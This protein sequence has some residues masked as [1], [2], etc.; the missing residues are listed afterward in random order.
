M[1]VFLCKKSK[2]HEIHKNFNKR[3]NNGTFN[4]ISTQATNNRTLMI[5][6][7]S[8]GFGRI[9]RKIIAY[10]E[11]DRWGYPED[12]IKAIAKHKPPLAK[13]R[14]SI[15][16][17]I[18][19]LKDDGNGILIPY[20]TRNL[21]TMGYR[22]YRKGMYPVPE[23]LTLDKENKEYIRYKMRQ[24]TLSELKVDCE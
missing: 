3:K 12:I 20:K 21:F 7:M 13:E 19:R 18:Q 24:S 14:S 2:E 5:Q 11:E 22:H 15:Y 17:S 9:Q 4:K 1:T 23:P 8:K 6:S 10:L 16:R